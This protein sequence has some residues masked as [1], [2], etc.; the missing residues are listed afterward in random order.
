MIG[1]TISH[2]TILEK[3]GGG[4]MGV[5]YKAEDT[6]LNRFVALKFLPQEV[7]NDPQ[8]LARFRREAQAASALNHPNICTIHDIGEENGQAFIAMEFLDGTTLK[9]RI[10]GKP[11]DLEEMLG[12]AIEIADALDAA[13]AQGIV[14]RDIKPANLFVTKRGHAKIL[15]FG[16]AKVAKAQGSTTIAPSAS[17]T[18]AAV[19]ETIVGEHL[20]SP[21]TTL[22]TVAYMSPEQVRAKD[23]DGRSDLFSFG[24]VLYEMATG[25]LPF[26]GESSAVIFK[27]ILDTQP[28]AVVRLNPDVPPE[29]ERILSKALEKDRNLR[30]Q[31]AAEMRSDLQRLKR[32]T[33]SGKTVSAV[34]EPAKGRRT[35]TITALVGVIVIALLAFG[36]W[37][38]RSAGKGRI[39]SIAVL[40]FANAGSDASADYVGDGMTESLISSLTHLSDL[41]VKSRSSVFRY[42]GKDVDVQKVGRDL[43]VGAVLTGRVVP[44]GNSLQVSAEL[45]NVA[46]NTELWGQQYSGSRS[47]MIALQQQIAGDLAQRL[48]SDLSGTQKQQV[49]RQGTANPE[50][51]DLYMKGRYAWSKRTLPDLKQ[52]VSYF[53]RAIGLDPKYAT[54]WLGLGDAWG[55]MTA[56]GG[57]QNEAYAKSN[58]A[59]RK[60]LDLDPSMA[61]AHAILGANYFEKDWDFAGGEAELKKAMQLDPNDA[62]AYQWYAE[63]LA[64]I[65]GREQ[66]AI[67][68]IDRARQLD[69]ASFIIQAEAGTI[70]VWSRKYDDGLQICQKLIAE[71]PGFPRGHLCLAQA[72]KFKG[73][74]PEAIAEFRAA[75]N[76]S[77]VPSEIETI[78][79][80]EEGFRKGGFKVAVHRVAESLVERRA[81]GEPML[82]SDI[83]KIYAS[84]GDREATFTWLETAFREHDRGMIELRQSEDYQWLQSDPRMQALI[85]RVGLP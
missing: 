54:A 45:T 10:G 78:R 53:D 28:T 66:E 42:R 2:Y 13:H 38:W 63:D 41:K 31:G 3:L 29:L 35:V 27:S 80:A 76:L 47:D 49:M 69:P 73:M 20:T 59:A 18:A 83:A 61:H 40:P 43:G 51:Y 79:A 11:M 16:L 1:Q 77:G 26:R 55:S 70:R 52:A 65:G 22:G 6:R 71:A 39:E 33:D 85:K 44:Q 46:D 21:G 9:H 5:V 64:E 8:T 72:Y 24:A 48:R 50:A 17:T 60:A 56:Y 57:D 67:S 25:Q 62:T 84:S 32:D 19:A 23:L 37:M 82:A 75:A 12:L 34:V 58:A 4:G 14:H 7:A 81:K 36:L 68:A 74:Y 15:D 30:Y